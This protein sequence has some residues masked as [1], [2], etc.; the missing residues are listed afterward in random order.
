MNSTRKL[1]VLVIDPWFLEYTQGLCEYIQKE[2]NLEIVSSYENEKIY[3][4]EFN[5]YPFYFKYSAQIK[6]NYLMKIL[7]GLEYAVA[8]IKTLM[9]I[10]EKKYDIVHIQ[11]LLFYPVDALFLKIM[12]KMNTKIV[13]TAHNAVPHT[14]K[15]SLYIQCLNIIYK[16]VDLILVH[17]KEIKEELFS[18]FNIPREKVLLQKFGFYTK[19]KN[20]ENSMNEE[21]KDFL[22]K[23][24]QYNGKKVV[25]LGNIFKNKGVDRLFE[26]WIKHSNEFLDDCMIICGAIDEKYCGF[27]NLAL[28]F[29]NLKN[30]LYL[31]KRFSEGFHNSLLMSADIILLPYR[32]ASMSGVIFTAAQFSK[33]I[34]ST[35]T[36][37]IGE[38]IKDCPGAL[39]VHN[40]NEAF[41]TA[42]LDVF[43]Y[44]KEELIKKGQEFREYMSKKYSWDIVSKDV[45]N[46]YRRII[47]NE[48][49]TIQ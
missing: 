8:C 6:N 26:F 18:F 17:G 32:H 23:V 49:T 46:I 7:K 13:Y 29:S 5:I 3:N 19:H 45:V 31:P 2:I 43:N 4:N 34:I 48:N 27:D 28:Q 15:D 21:E 24:K 41:E 36:G 37:A 22:R 9:L 44:S 40:T 20:M 35:N 16:S 14:K 12:S 47:E 11:W 42:L 1:N 38:Y 10:F 39:L 33:M 25:Y 30:A